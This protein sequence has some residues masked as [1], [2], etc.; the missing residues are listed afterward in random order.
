MYIIDLKKKEKKLITISIIIL[1][2]IQK[3]CIAIIRMC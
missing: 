3:K 2:Y 1:F